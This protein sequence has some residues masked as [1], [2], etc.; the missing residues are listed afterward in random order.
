MTSA[1]LIQKFNLH[2]DNI[3]SAA[4][5][6]LNEYEISLFLTQAHKEVVASYYNGIMGGDTVDSTEATKSLISRYILTDSASL[7]PRNSAVLI[8][9]LYQYYIPL[10]EDVLQLLAERMY[11][12]EPLQ[13]TNILVKPIQIDQIYRLIENPFRRPSDKRV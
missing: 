8:K 4:A 5:P 7:I 13:Q 11:P 10:K 1:E 2:Y 9:G 12:K 3:L 6:G